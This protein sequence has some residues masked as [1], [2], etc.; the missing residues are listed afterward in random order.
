MWGRGMHVTYV[1]RYK[2]GI[3]IIWKQSLM[4][5]YLQFG[6]AQSVLS[7]SKIWRVQLIWCMYVSKDGRSGTRIVSYVSYGAHSIWGMMLL[8][9]KVRV[10]DS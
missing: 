7:R 3:I 2:W 8:P 5:F 1:S 6:L 10:E 9:V 4:V